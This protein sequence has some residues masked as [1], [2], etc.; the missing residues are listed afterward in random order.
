MS[1][2]LYPMDSFHR[3]QSLTCFCLVCIPFYLLS[4]F[5]IYSRSIY[6]SSQS[7]TESS[8]SLSLS[9]FS[10]PFI[11]LQFPHLRDNVHVCASIFP[12]TCFSSKPFLVSSRVNQFLTAQLEWTLHISPFYSSLNSL[13]WN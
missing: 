2:C 11:F 5:I 9:H 7:S 1:M 3:P 8:L 13:D 12:R 6:Q 10:P 4:S